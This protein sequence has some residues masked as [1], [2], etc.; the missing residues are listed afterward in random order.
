MPRAPN[1]WEAPKSP[2]DDA[3][4]FFNILYLLPKDLRF[5]HGGDKLVSCPGRH[6]VG[7][8]LA[9]RSGRRHWS[10][11]LR[12]D[13]CSKCFSLVCRQQFVELLIIVKQV[14]L[15]CF[16]DPIRVPKIKNLVPTIREIGSLQVHIGYLAF[17]FKKT[18]EVTVGSSTGETT[19][20]KSD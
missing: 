19:T 14:F 12:F 15:R 5:E 4:K 3:S 20:G 7:T 1:H 13:G 11:D 16:T 10:K 17:S 8:P 6:N 2:N 18:G 9:A